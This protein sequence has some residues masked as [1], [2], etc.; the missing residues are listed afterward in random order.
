MN[1]RTF[2]VKI[3]KLLSQEIYKWKI[4]DPYHGGIPDTYYSGPANFCFIEYK[5][6]PQLPAKNMSKLNFGLTEQQKLWLI[7][8]QEFDIPVFVAAG[9][10]NRVVLTEDFESVNYYTKQTFSQVSLSVPDFIQKL[11]LHCLGSKRG[12]NDNS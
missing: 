10:E 3:H 1:E 8:Q 5:Y 11:E 12:Q 4:N 9:C 2:I 6:K 7:K